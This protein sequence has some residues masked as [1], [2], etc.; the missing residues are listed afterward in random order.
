MRDTRGANKLSMNLNLG[1]TI[2]PKNMPPSS[3][4]NQVQTWFG[5]VSACDNAILHLRDLKRVIG[6]LPTLAT[7]ANLIILS[8]VISA[9][10]SLHPPIL[11]S[12]KV[13]GWF[14][15]FYPGCRWTLRRGYYDDDD[16]LIVRRCS[17]C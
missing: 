11:I 3:S 8:A 9:P 4:S 13:R 17:V 5:T 1:Q 15:G 16:T 14:G 12:R 6:M 7:I 10:L 2:N